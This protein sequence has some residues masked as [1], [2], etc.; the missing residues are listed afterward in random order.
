MNWIRH[1][2][3]GILL[4]ACLVACAGSLQFAN[5]FVVEETDIH[6]LILPP[7]TLLKSYAPE[8]P[9]SIPAD[10]IRGPGDP[11]ALFVNEVVDS[12]FI[13]QFMSS[14]KY[15]LDLFQVKAYG[16]DQMD[17]FFA[18]DQ[19][20]YIFVLAQ[21]ELLEYVDEEVFMGRSGVNRYIGRVD[22][23]VLENNVWWEFAKLHDAGFGMEVLFNAHATSD[24]VEG[25]FIRLSTGQVRFQP[26]K[27]L[28]TQEDVSDLAYFSGRQNAQNIFDHLMNIY[29][30]KQSGREY[31]YYFHYDIEEHV[32]RERE[33]PPFIRIEPRNDSPDED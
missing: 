23:T 1:I 17:Q 28:L 31:P 20:A 12:V 5:R 26:Q 29:V 10:S 18:L 6:V 25:R 3:L 4:N 30:R 2:G 19:P 22:I 27:Y 16:P 33:Y 8:H 21:I 32:I 24:H 15:H 9:D 7:G 11:R 14:L 13:D